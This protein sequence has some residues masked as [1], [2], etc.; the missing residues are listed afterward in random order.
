MWIVPLFITLFAFQPLIADEPL[1]FN[2]KKFILTNKEWKERLTKE[3]YKILRKGKT[4]RPFANQYY[5][6]KEPGLY[7]CAGCHLPL[8]S[9]EAKY[10][11]GTGWPSFWEPVCAQNVSTKEDFSFF[12]NR[13]EVLCNRCDGHLGH[14]FDDGPPPTNKRYCL[15]SAAL[16]FEP[17]KSIHDDSFLLD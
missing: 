12:Q 15:N 11:S 6:S 13:V 8:F 5:D 10:D 9:S 2:G 17:E 14:L 3:Q 4:E 7:V 16:L 1:C